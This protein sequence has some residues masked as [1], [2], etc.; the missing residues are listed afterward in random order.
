MV[1]SFFGRVNPMYLQTQNLGLEISRGFYT[2]TTLDR[3][4]VPWNIYIFGKHY[5][6]KMKFAKLFWGFKVT[7]IQGF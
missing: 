5:I 7:G 2:I 6:D 1:I 4:L 3:N